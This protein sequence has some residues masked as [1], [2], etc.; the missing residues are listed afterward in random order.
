MSEAALS[1]RLLDQLGPAG[2]VRLAELRGGTRLYVPASIDGWE[3]TPRLGADLAEKLVATD[4]G[5]QIRVPLARE[6]R[7]RHYRAHGKSNAK[8]A[9]LL[10]MTEPGVDAMFARMA[11]KPGGKPVK[12]AGQ[13]NLFPQD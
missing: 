9:V 3:L 11:A 12:G 1:Q 5:T 8:I 7:A 13:L 4:G 6:L 10:G 2:L